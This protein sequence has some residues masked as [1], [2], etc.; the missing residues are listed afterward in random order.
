MENRSNLMKFDYMTEETVI[1]I[2]TLAELI[3]VNMEDIFTVIHTGNIPV[4]VLSGKRLSVFKADNPS[5]KTN[6]NKVIML[7]YSMCIEIANKFEGRKRYFAILDCFFSEEIE[8]YKLDSLDFDINSFDYG[9]ALL[10]DMMKSVKFTSDNRDTIIDIIESNKLGNP[11]WIND[12][13]SLTSLEYHRL[14]YNYFYMGELLLKQGVVPNKYLI[15]KTM[16]EK[17]FEESIE[18]K[19]Y[20]SMLDIVQ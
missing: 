2:P 17:D 4:L 1:T 18:S 19:F 5:F 16:A 9:K 11:S 8:G 3:G 12:A 20:V 10:E 7:D 13:I 14:Y 6:L 15:V